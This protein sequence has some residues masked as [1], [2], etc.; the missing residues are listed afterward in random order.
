MFRICWT[1][2]SPHSGGAAGCSHSAS[3]GT[4]QET[5][6]QAAALHVALEGAGEGR[7]DALGD[8]LE[9]GEAERVAVVL[10]VGSTPRPR[11]AGRVVVDLPAHP[12]LQQ[13]LRHRLPVQLAG[14]RQP[15]GGGGDDRAARRAG[16][17]DPGR[18]RH[19]PVRVG[20]AEHR[21]VVA[22]ADRERV[23]QGVVEGQLAAGEVAHGDRAVGVAVGRQV[24]GDERV[25]LPAV[26]AVVLA[27]PAV[28]DVVGVVP[29]LGR[30]VVLQVERLGVAGRGDPDAGLVAVLVE[31]RARERVRVGEARAPPTGCRSSGR[32]CGSPASGSRC[33]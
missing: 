16:R 4:I 3:G 27:G 18:H 5:L 26:P 15:V 22:V 9:A 17:V 11:Q 33:A 31:D 20:R 19:Q 8:Q 12:G 23:G 13:R 7:G 24:R 30:R 1:R 25:H 32:S 6:G 21:A 10:E 2:Y 29:V 14:H 28:V